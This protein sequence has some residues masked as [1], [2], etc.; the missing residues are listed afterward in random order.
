MLPFVFTFITL[1]A[2]AA[3]LGQLM[4]LGSLGQPVDVKHD[5][6]A[7]RPH[8]WLKSFYINP[9][10][11]RGWVPKVWGFGQTV[12][13]RTKLQAKLSSVRVRDARCHRLL[14]THLPTLV[15][16]LSPLSRVRPLSDARRCPW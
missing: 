10:D 1:A 8:I 7:M 4:W 15:G 16:N 13:F 9:D 6:E 14:L 12:N 11:P 5:P 3:L 2:A